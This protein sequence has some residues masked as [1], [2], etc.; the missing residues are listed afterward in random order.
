MGKL[1]EGKRAIVTGAGQGLGLAVSLALA[2]DGAKVLLTSRSAEKARASVEWIRARG[3]EAE[4]MEVD[5]L[6]PG[7]PERVV[8]A[9]VERFGG[10][11]VLV[12]NA[13]FF[14]WRKFLELSGEEWS[15]TIDTNL[16]A[17]FLLTQAVARVMVRQGRGGAIVNIASI[18][19][20]VA[21]AEA[22]AQSAAKFGLLGLTYSAAAALREHDIRVNAICP[23]SIEP[24]SAER[25]APSPREKVTQAD[26]ATMVSYLASDLA[27][28]ITATAIDVFG[29]TQVE[30]KP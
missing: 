19:A 26:I 23:G 30:I 16:S 1:L 4:G 6:A 17:P 3:A 9:A 14:Q 5:L 21:D 28:S 7:A 11:E 27:R 2:V 24:D 20:R 25:R 8:Q 18:H 29:G 15:Q 10:V 13:G 22:T 12:N